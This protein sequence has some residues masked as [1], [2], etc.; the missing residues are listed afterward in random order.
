MQTLQRERLQQ[1]LRLAISL[2]KKCIKS[3]SEK[4]NLY[5]NIKSEI[6]ELERGRLKEGKIEIEIRAE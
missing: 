6:N 2:I 1:F 5:K 3:G 4:L